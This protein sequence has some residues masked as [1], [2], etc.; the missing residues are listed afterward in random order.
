MY[1]VFGEICLLPFIYFDTFPLIIVVYLIQPCL[2]FSRQLIYCVFCTCCPGVLEFYI[3]GKPNNARKCWTCDPLTVIEMSCELNILSDVLL[4]R[5][6]TPDNSKRAF[7]FFCYLCVFA[8]LLL[9]RDIRSISV[10]YCKRYFSPA[11][12]FCIFFLSLF[13]C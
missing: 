4:T 2:C 11:S 6:T 7:S 13:S 5:Q 8:F 12:T 1:W 10:T 3:N 9:Q